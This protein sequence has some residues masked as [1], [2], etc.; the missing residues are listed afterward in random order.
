MKI[1]QVCCG[2]RSV[3]KLSF[4]NLEAVRSLCT[5]CLWKDQIKVVITVTGSCISVEGMS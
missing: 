4:D 1:T 3:L 2:T 5:H